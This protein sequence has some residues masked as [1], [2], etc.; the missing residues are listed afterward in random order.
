MLKFEKGMRKSEESLKELLD[1]IKQNPDLPVFPII[2]EN[3]C[4][5]IEF[6]TI[7]NLC[8]FEHPYKMKYC[9]HALGD[10]KVEMYSEWTKADVELD[11]KKKGVKV[12]W[13]NAI[14][15]PLSICET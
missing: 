4:N 15:V 6:N 9:Y 7:F 14:F 10:G 1:L 3:I 5:D 11:A 2:D 13:K 12:D 8:Q